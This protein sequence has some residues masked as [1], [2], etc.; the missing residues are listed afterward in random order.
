MLNYFFATMMTDMPVPL[1]SM[2]K[3][4]NLKPRSNLDKREDEGQTNTAALCDINC[5]AS[6]KVN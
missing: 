1:P 5:L 4:S 3:G 6:M 2:I